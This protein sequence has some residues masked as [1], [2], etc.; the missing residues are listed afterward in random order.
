MGQFRSRGAQSSST[1]AAS[2]GGLLSRFLLFGGRDVAIRTPEMSQR[3][4][5]RSAVS[6][7]TTEIRS[8]VLKKVD[9]DTVVRIQTRLTSKVKKGMYR[10]QT[11]AQFGH[12]NSKQTL[13]TLLLSPEESSSA[14]PHSER[15]SHSWAWLREE[16]F[17]TWCTL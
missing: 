16:E 14:A 3:R 11:T 6:Q 7:Q 13:N 9:S 4:E 2:G 10:K 15:S 17:D 8:E 1:K 5:E 12:C